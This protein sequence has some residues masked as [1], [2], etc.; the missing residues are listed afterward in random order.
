MT[1]GFRAD[2]AADA[3]A[4]RTYCVIEPGPTIKLYHDRELIHE[5]TLSRAEALL[6]I[7]KLAAE[8]KP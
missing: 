4:A 6:M 1:S 7:E 3:I 5:A 2:S 8:V